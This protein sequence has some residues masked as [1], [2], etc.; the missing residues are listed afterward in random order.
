MD[1]F[2]KTLPNIK[3][4]E[5][6][7]IIG[8]EN[9][10]C[11]K[12][13]E[14]YF[15]FYEHESVVI[16]VPDD[17]FNDRYN[18]SF[19]LKGEV[20]IPYNYRFEN[21]YPPFL[22]MI[23]DSLTEEN[24]E[25]Y[26]NFGDFNKEY[27]RS[28]YDLV[29][30]DLK[31]GEKITLSFNGLFDKVSTADELYVS[32][33]IY[34]GEKFKHGY[35]DEPSRT[36]KINIKNST[37]LI[38]YKRSIV[39]ADDVDFIMLKICSKGYDGVGKMTV[40]ILE[41]DGVVLSDAFE[42]DKN[43]EYNFKWVGEAFTLINRPSFIVEFNGTK[44][45]DGKK[46]DRMNC[47]GSVEF[48]LPYEL[49]K[50]TGN[51]VK[52][53]L[54]D[55][56]RFGYRF[57]F[58]YLLTAPHEFEVLAYNKIASLNKDFGI[59]FYLPKKGK[60]KISSKTPISIIGDN[61]FE[62]GYNV[63][64]FKPEEIASNVKIKVYALGKKRTIVLD[65]IVEKEEDNVKAGTGD[66]IYIGNSISDFY[67]YFTWYTSENIGN[68]ITFRHTYH[69]GGASEFEPKFWKEV[70]KI[71]NDYKMYFVNMVDGRE[72]NGVNA[73]PTA[74]V[75]KSPYF[76]GDQSHEM[77]GS[78]TYWTQD[79]STRHHE[80][81]YHA[82][83]RKLQH[84]GIYGKHSPVYDAKGNPRIFYA[85]DS[86][87]D[88]KE[89]Y[90]NF[91][92][93]IRKTRI[94]NPTRH[95][96]VTPMFDTFFRNGYEWLGAETTYNSTEILLGA[97]RGISKSYGKYSFG[98][99]IATQWSTVPLDTIG[100][101]KR[102]FLSLFIC[103]M[104]GVTDINTEEGLWILENN[105]S[106]F[107]RFSEACINHKRVH[108]LFSR[109]IATHTRRGTIKADGAMVIGKYDG[110]SMFGQKQVYGQKSK[111]FTISTPEKSW[112]ILK[113][114]YPNANLDQIYY[115]TKEGGRKSLTEK[116]KTLLTV[117]EYNYKDE[118][119][120]GDVSSTPNGNVD[121][122]SYTAKNYSEYKYLF[123]TGW[124][125]LDE[126]TADKLLDY[127]KQGGKLL[128]AKPHL[129]TTVVRSEAIKG[130]SKLLDTDSAKIIS[131]TS[132]KT[133]YV[134][135]ENV[136]VYK[137]QIG[138]GVL[139]Y[140]DSNEYPVA[141]KEVY[142]K[143]LDEIT[144][145]KYAISDTDFISY[146]QYENGDND[147]FYL[148]NIR[149]WSNRKATAK[150]TFGDKDYRIKLNNME[151]GVLTKGK[152]LAVLTTNLEC[153]VIKVVN[154]KIVLQGNGKTKL[155]IYSTKQVNNVMFNGK[156]VKYYQDK[157]GVVTMYL[158][159]SGKGTI[160]VD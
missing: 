131:D 2:L 125:T 159:L 78:Y 30:A 52:I 81:N 1:K 143:L 120:F 7:Y 4:F 73:G 25:L 142:Y 149:W 85:P 13:K 42:F 157:N 32:A 129:F 144:V 72:L 130:T 107:D 14:G 53:T 65:R 105:F 154:N 8:N 95:T 97:L 104:H 90:E 49:R 126:E 109:F 5:D 26:L 37:S 147:I 103:Y 145:D 39:L 86:A 18:Y 48:L 124:N 56:N 27:E 58:P 68:F 60:I 99:H 123:F 87:K 75:L 114:F 89:A 76:L 88:M 66:A 64:T 140:C 133:P 46:F 148:L 38:N 59:L 128:L 50:P 113:Y 21:F 11:K 63:L 29:R 70:V 67:R 122:I 23:D 110:F 91:Y 24:G 34:Y 41:K 139:Y 9:F 116:D 141:Y 112:W 6:R 54:K 134:T 156:T 106:D 51:Q 77:D 111:E 82:M 69:W 16:N 146:T 33:E 132:G 17:A 79:I 150:F 74:S 71:V 22:Q 12:D 160:I 61:V 108:Q 40:P 96:G 115:C 121:L 136:K 153:D 98:S 151:F 102:Y 19:H 44:I 93:G 135:A 20:A 57:Q 31:K 62:K 55:H 119:A 43:F 47:C 101:Y 94:S 80:T 45:F 35:Y 92:D 155:N 118:G 15:I 36:V 127:V 137:T 10:S 84:V 83:S 138:K 28:A 3:G 100:H 152:E 117:R 158:N